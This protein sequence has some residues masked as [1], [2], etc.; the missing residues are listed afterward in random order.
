MYYTGI[1]R[2]VDEMG[3]IVLPA[4]LRRSLELETGTPL[5]ILTDGNSIVL[6]KS[7]HQCAFCGTNNEEELS[8]YRGKYICDQCRRDLGRV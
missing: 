4:E 7:A 5:E 3:R 2:R 8:P 1:T 6:R